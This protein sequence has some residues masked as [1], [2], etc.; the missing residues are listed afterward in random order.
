MK[1]AKTRALKKRKAQHKQPV[2]SQH[3]AKTHKPAS[4]APKAKKAHKAPVKKT[5]AQARTA[6]ARALSPGGVSCCSALA[7]AASA[8]LSGWPV[9][10]EDVLDLYRLT[11]DSHS[12]APSI[13]ATL[14]AAYVFGLAGVRPV[15]FEPVDLDDPAAVILG[16]DLPEAPH[17]VTLDPSGAVWSWDA[18]YDL[19]SE[20]V[21]EEAWLV[22]WPRCAVAFR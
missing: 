13:L 10:D 8:R 16:L 9:A 3:A 5:A 21:V 19:T 2:H 12:A 7:V 14:D 20:A 18:L 11:A 6:H 15:S 4:K 17:A 22:T 1:S